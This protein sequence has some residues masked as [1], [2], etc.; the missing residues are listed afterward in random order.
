[1]RIVLSV[2]MLCG[3]AMGQK[4]YGTVAPD[5]IKSVPCNTRA[6]MA[7][8][9]GNWIVMSGEKGIVCVP[10]P[11]PTDIQAH[12]EE[13]TD[14]LWWNVTPD[15]DLVQM[16]GVQ[17]RWACPDQDYILYSNPDGHGTW[18]CHLPKSY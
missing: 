13:T 17:R 5:P 10:P 9:P 12:L 1:M 8:A 6:E 18:W 16:K 11:R 4:P 7:K 14:D 3:I 15:S 2:V